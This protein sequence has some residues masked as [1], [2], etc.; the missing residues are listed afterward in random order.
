[1]ILTQVIIELILQKTCPNTVMILLLTL[2]NTT[3]R[4][5]RVT[6]FSLP[7]ITI[8]KSHSDSSRVALR[9]KFKT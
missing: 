4:D 7:G 9:W 6:T 1:M 8:D 2:F 5:Q 3:Y